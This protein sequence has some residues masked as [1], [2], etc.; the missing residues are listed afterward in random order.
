MACELKLQ[1][2]NYNT[3]TNKVEVSE[4]AIGTIAEDGQV[5]YDY[6]ASIISQLDK[7]TR[8]ALA[9]QL[10]VAKVQKI[11]NNTW[12]NHQ[13]ISNTSLNELIEQYPD[14]EKYNIPKDLQYNFTLLK[15]YKAEFNGTAYKGRA[16]NS[17]GEEIFIINNIFDAEK[18][19][20][21]LQ[22]KLNLVKFIQGNNVDKSLKEY[23]EDLDI[24]T[25]HYRRDNIQRLIEDFLIDKHAYLP[26]K[27]GGKL[28]NPR[29]IINKVLSQITG[30]LYDEG[31]KS[32]L[33]VALE[34]IK[35]KSSNNDAWVFDKKKLYDVLEIFSEDIKNIPFDQF[36][37]LDT[38]TLNDLLYNIFKNDVHLIK[39]KVIQA[40]QGKQII[41]EPKTEKQRKRVPSEIIQ[42]IYDNSFKP[43]NPEL[44]KTY[45]AAA[46]KLGYLFNEIIE[47]ANQ[48]SPIT[49]TDET[50]IEREVY[51]EM[52]EKFNVKAYYEVETQPKIKEVGASITI[53]LN[54]F[55]PIGKIYDFSYDTQ[56]IYSFVEQYKGFYIYEFYRDGTTHYAISRSIISPNAYMSTY[57]SLDKAKAAVD[58]NKDT[59][60]QC[61]LWSIK[62]FTG[63]PRVS[64]IEMKSVK[65][66]SIITTLDIE[67]PKYNK[68]NFSDTV[69][70]LLKGTVANFQ[71]K[72][73]FIEN[74][75]SLDTP[76]KATAFIYLA[77]QTLKTGQDFIEALQ[78]N[79]EKVQSIITKINNSKPISYFIEKVDNFGKAYLK[80]LKNNGTNVDVDGKIPDLSMQDFVDY[81]LNELIDY[82]NQSFGIKVTG[83]T[84]T[85]LAIFNAENN[86]GMEHKLDTINA[87][88][89]NGQIYIVTSNASVE[90]LFHELSHIFLGVLKASDPEA[91]QEVIKSYT[92]QST[93][94]YLHQNHK[95]TYK[96][97]SEEDVAEETVAD[98][99]AE[100]L[101]QAKQLGT[102]DLQGDQVLGLFEEIFKRSNRFTKSLQDN[103]L[104]FQKYMRNLLD[105]N[106]GTMER[107]MRISNLVQQLISDGKIKENCL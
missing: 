88:V 81:N 103:G 76:E 65:A 107:N 46:K 21:H 13:L 92:T 83:L 102:N 99:I 74:I 73:R 100:K 90:N 37:Q 22:V 12:D 41:T 56:N 23:Q 31:D 39:A 98:M 52:D 16:V 104:G 51:F 86:L 58:K 45:Q 94:K 71:D 80:L 50:G 34:A 105:E 75:D 10:R 54:K 35:N 25:K 20:K 78:E 64:E 57:S 61:G 33:H 32:E 27:V 63:S 59:L 24:I 106:A 96:H 85:E 14:L 36:K 26:F 38:Q 95:Q 18:L 66:G 30:E 67:L 5:N 48:G 28:Y 2:S 68:K 69:K 89:H 3:D 91:Y 6:V 15:C 7:D 11:N 82:F 49:I 8:S 87:F 44:P 40:S 77:Q 4:I 70:Q 60:E 53:E 79:T 93:Y 43:N 97:Y 101:F 84:R 19:F 47:Q 9:A 62:Q 1:I 42:Q 17:K 29:R 72:L 55:D